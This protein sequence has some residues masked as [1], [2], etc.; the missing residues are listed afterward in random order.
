MQQHVAGLFI[1]NGSFPVCLILEEGNCLH[2]KETVRAL[3]KMQ[4]FMLGEQM[5]EAS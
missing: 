1:L 2:N 5:T 4:T 3:L